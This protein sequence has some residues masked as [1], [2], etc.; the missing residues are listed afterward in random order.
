MKFIQFLI[1]IL[2]WIYP[3]LMKSE[4]FDYNLTIQL[5]DFIK[6]K[7]ARIGIAVISQGGDT[8]SVN[9]DERFPMLSVY[10]FPQALAVAHYCILNS[11]SFQDSIPISK[12]L[13]KEGTYSPL[14]DKY[15]I[16]DIKLSISEL[17]SYSLQLSDN[18]ACDILFDL[19][20]GVNYAEIMISEMGFQGIKIKNTEDELHD[21]YKL[22][23]ENSSTPLEMCKLVSYF[24]NELTQVAPEF[25]FIGELL[26][27][28]QTGLDRLS[29]G[30]KAG[31]I[32]GHKTGTGD[33]NSEGKIIAINDVGYIKLCNGIGYSIVVFISDS[34]YDMTTTSGFIGEIS[35]I[36]SFYF[37]TVTD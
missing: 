11:I 2:L 31:D 12:L 33:I 23:Y 17:L 19:I 10:K 4:D 25:H 1:L 14:R 18:N 7:K 35:Q 3:T 13:I 22:C 28:C 34:E 36:I 8:I 32:I 5:E 21:N 24:T 15:G 6:N 30:I 29:K 26:E 20:G 27:T 16:T 9:G 37:H